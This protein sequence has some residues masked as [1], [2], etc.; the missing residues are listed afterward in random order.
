MPLAF[1]IVGILFLVAAVRGKEYSDELLSTI[2]SDFTGPKNFFYWGI[3]LFVI[4][5]VGYYKPL[6]PMST[7]FMTLVVIV[8]FFSNKGFP[9]K[10]LEQIGSTTVHQ[11]SAIVLTD[12][13]AAL[14]R[15]ANEVTAMGVDK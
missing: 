3:A 2:K 6:K 12:P 8:L 7:A 9:Q 10:F 14:A 15:Y 4:G 13:L 1:A 11:D 5:A